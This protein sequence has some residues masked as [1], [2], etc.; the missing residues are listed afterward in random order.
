M[1]FHVTIMATALLTRK[2]ERVQLGLFCLASECRQG[3]A[4][5]DALTPSRQPWLSLGAGPTLH[6][7]VSAHSSAVH[8]HAC[9]PAGGHSILGGLSDGIAL[10]ML[11][12][13]TWDVS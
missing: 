4:S 11:N 2:Y 1:A 10:Q 8:A 9:V 12:Q 3:H 6:L 13:D 5:R 7:A